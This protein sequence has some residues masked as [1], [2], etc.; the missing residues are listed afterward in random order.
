MNDQDNM[1]QA[2]D[3]KAKI[4]YGII[5]LLVIALV[6]FG[7]W[8]TQQ[9]KIN[10]LENRITELQQKIDELSKPKDTISDILESGS[11]T[12]RDSERTTDIKAIHG[13]VEA[14]FAQYGYYPTLSNLNDKNFR[15]NNLQGLEDDSL[16]DPQGD[17]SSLVSSPQAKA[18]SYEVTP[19]SCDNKKKDCT[20]YTLTA[21]LET[22]GTFEKQSLN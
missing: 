19:S 2:K 13:Q 5:V 1:H 15:T 14:Y 16:R 3:S 21:T 22:G 12:A 17:S 9:N 10:K 6:S 7:V 11:Q 20:T 4:L 8:F 18:Y